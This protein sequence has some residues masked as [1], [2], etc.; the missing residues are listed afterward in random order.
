MA[1]MLCVFGFSISCGASQS[2]NDDAGNSAV[3]EEN[4][5]AEDSSEETSNYKKT[6][7]MSI[8][9]TVSTDE[10]EFRLISVQFAEALTAVSGNSGAPVESDVYYLPADTEYKRSSENARWIDAASG[11]VYFTFSFSLNYIG[12][13][14][15]S[16]TPPSD[17]S[18]LY[19][20]TYT[21]SNTS[22]ALSGNGEVWSTLIHDFEPL[23]NSV[24]GRGYI[25]G[26]STQV[27]ED[28]ESALQ[29]SVNLYG[30]EFIY[31]FSVGDAIIDE[32]EPYADTDLLEMAEEFGDEDGHI[33][34]SEGSFP[35]F[36]DMRESW[37]QLTTEEIQAGIVGTW[38]VRE[39]TDKPTSERLYTFSPDGTGTYTSALR[40]EEETF[41][42]DA[43]N[44]T[45]VYSL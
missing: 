26:I 20:N 37:D 31:G 40:G 13:E 25:E 24:Q 18:L 45:F 29:L 22:V 27:I 12:T 42:W 16:A 44:G 6:E 36:I 30:T 28:E 4:T 19:D 34:W 38:N 5:G 8:G 33:S 10:W 2:E 3:V 17:I 23:S 39:Y 11:T 21:F 7:I 14:S 9:D 43:K 15:Q 35:Y 1:I 41:Y 32:T